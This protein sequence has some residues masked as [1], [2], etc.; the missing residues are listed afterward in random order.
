MNELMTMAIPLAPPHAILWGI[1][2]ETNPTAVRIA[3]IVDKRYSLK[4]CLNMSSPPTLITEGTG[5]LIHTR[6]F[7]GKFLINVPV[8]SDFLCGI[9]FLCYNCYERLK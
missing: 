5:T 9:F 2:K 6:N 1:R 4:R 3:P 7:R 8:P